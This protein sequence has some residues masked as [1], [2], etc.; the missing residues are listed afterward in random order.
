MQVAQAAQAGI[1]TLFDEDQNALIPQSARGYINNDAMMKIVFKVEGT[2]LGRVF[3][4]GKSVS[5][6]DVNFAHHYP[7]GSGDL[8]LLP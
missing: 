2:L 7:L 6:D 3:S 5:I 1:V 8:L 4:E